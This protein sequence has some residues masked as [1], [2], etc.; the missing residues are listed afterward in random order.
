MTG[1]LLCIAGAVNILALSKG[2]FLKHLSLFFG[3]LLCFSI[4]GILFCISIFGILLWRKAIPFYEFFQVLKWQLPISWQTTL[5][6]TP[7]LEKLH[8][9]LVL[10]RFIDAKESVL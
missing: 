4:F 3:I 8:C 10:T 7:C 1:Y 9:R 6:L 2:P 5:R